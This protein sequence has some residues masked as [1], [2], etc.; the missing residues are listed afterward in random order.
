MRIIDYQHVQSCVQEEGPF[1]LI[2]LDVP[3][4]NTGVLAK[5]VE[6]RFRCNP[7]AI[8]AC[9]EIQMQ[10]LKSAAG[11]LKPGGR[12]C[13][14]TCSIMRAENQDRVAR[15]LARDRRFLLEQ[16]RLTLPTAHLPDS[17]GAYVALLK[18]K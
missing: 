13:Y 15:F 17:D 1:D 2:L 3:C 10:L 4:S 11:M 7:Q 18:I 14:S 16:E 5:R 12:I 9:A 6:V 8:E